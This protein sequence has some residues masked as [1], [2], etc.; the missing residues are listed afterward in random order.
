MTS[1]AACGASGDDVPSSPA[2]PGVGYTEEDAGYPEEDPG[3]YTDPGYPEEDPGYTDP[4]ETNP[5]AFAGD[6]LCP[7]TPIQVPPPNL[8]PDGGW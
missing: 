2:D 4:G 1:V 5:C 7:D 8:G 6:P 3:Y